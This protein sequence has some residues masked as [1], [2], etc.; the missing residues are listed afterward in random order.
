MIITHAPSS[1]TSPMALMTV[2]DDY[3]V[4]GGLPGVSTLASPLVLGIGSYLLAKKFGMGSTSKWIAGAVVL[5]RYLLMKSEAE[6][7][8]LG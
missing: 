4:V 5:G 7:R 2:G 3:E 1:P 6:A 8:K